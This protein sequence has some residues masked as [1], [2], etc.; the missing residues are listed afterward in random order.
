MPT[1]LAKAGNIVTLNFE[2]SFPIIGDPTVTFKSGG[3]PVN[4]NIN[5][6]NSSNDH[7]TWVAFYEVASMDN[8]GVVTFT[9]SGTDY[10]G[11][12][13]TFTIPTE[14]APSSGV[15]IDTTSPSNFSISSVSS[16]GGTDA[17]ITSGYYNA[18]NTGIDIT[19][20]IANDDSLINGTVEVLTKT[21]NANFSSLQTETDIDNI[22]S[23]L[24]ISIA[25]SKLT[26]AVGWVDGN[27][28]VFQAI[29]NDHAGNPTTSTS[30]NPSLQLIIDTTAPSLEDVN[31]VSNN[32]SGTLAKKGNT[33][34]LS[35]TSSESIQRPTVTMSIDGSDVKDNVSISGTDTS[36][37][38]TH[39]VGDNENG[40]VTYTIDY[41]D[42]AGNSGSQVTSGTGSVTVDTTAPILTPGTPITTPSKIIQPQYVFT[43]TEQGTITTNI[44]EGFSATQVVNNNDGSFT[45]T[46]T[47][48][49]LDEGT[50]ENKTITVTDAAGNPS[51]SLII[52]KF[53][54]DTTAPDAPSFTSSTLTNITAPTITGTAEA[55]STVTLT[56]PN[57]A[58][59]TTTAG[60]D[61]SW[62]VALSSTTPDSGTL[63]LNLNDNNTI[64][65][66]ATDAANNVSDVATETLVI[67]TTAPTITNV[68]LAS[69]NTTI[70]V[71]FSEAVYNSDSGSGSLEVGDF[72]FALSSSS[73]GGDATLSSTTPSSISINENKYT[74]GISLSGT[75]DGSE[76]LTVNPVLNSIYDAV[77]NVASTS[78]SN[79]TKLL[80]DKLGP[81]MTISSSTVNSGESSNDP[82]ISL[83]FTSS[84]STTNF[85]KDVITISDGDLS[86]LSGSETTYTATL[87]PSIDTTYTINVAQNTFTDSSNNYNSASNPFTWTYDSTAPAPFNVGVVTA[88]GGTVK[89]NYW[90]STNENIS[91]TV[92]I[93]SDNTLVG[94]TVQLKVKIGSYN[95]KLGNEV[96][97]SQGDL[98]AN[99]VLQQNAA[100]LENVDTLRFVD[101]VNLTFTADI[102]DVNNNGPTTGTNSVNVLT[103]YQTAPII[104]I[105]GSNPLTIYER[106]NYTDPGATA[107][108]TLDN[109]LAVVTSSQVDPDVVGEYTVTYTATDDV[110]NVSTLSRIVN[111]LELNEISL[112][113]TSHSI[114]GYKD[115][116]T[117][118][119]NHVSDLKF[120][121]KNSS[122]VYTVL[123]SVDI[124]NKLRININGNDI[125]IPNGNLVARINTGG[126][127]DYVEQHINYE[128]TTNNNKIVINIPR[129][130]HLTNPSYTQILSSNTNNG[131]WYKNGQYTYSSPD[132][133]I[134][135]SDSSGS[136]Q[137]K[138]LHTFYAVNPN[139]LD[140]DNKN[141]THFYKFESEDNLLPAIGNMPSAS[142]T[143]FFGTGI[144]ERSI[145]S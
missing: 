102:T 33:I 137:L 11:K 85:I 29:I 78:Q 18:T 12:L 26:N 72:E 121:D 75:P 43:S 90:N 89:E 97:I 110:G 69:N 82:T 1:N 3:Q 4:N 103:V 56:V 35:F 81:T 84:E 5:Y 122:G 118:P 61:G 13:R 28:M 135:Y 119:L 58:V 134:N 30:N 109:Y 53:I 99:I 46:V 21:G 60:S 111:V 50:Y 67:D 44:F 77:G 15:T 59:Y 117:I 38:A 19:I 129:N 22:N 74:L 27:T 143:F 80:N 62:S 126:Y 108:D 96:T 144:Y 57:N 54:I 73:N 20:H 128:L 93:A 86:D 104:T 42:L 51:N 64:T 124:R 127:G 125:V 66:T 47:F 120:Y 31:L 7:R 70:V 9:I 115:V 83:T 105:L 133:Y 24:T 132:G 49:E 40:N 95:Y 140:S 34:T 25:N 68:S 130:K 23:D 100:V 145:D 112:N 79:N 87:T 94:G 114:S 71:T 92:P 98:G 2:T 16:T 8:D 36:W 101:G 106:D 76:T 14:N 136:A 65:A 6:T 91:V 39:A 138:V 142:N 131:I 113:S 139:T 10:K 48:N 52:P 17:V 32:P 55:N 88:G 41:N 37:T 63:N 116:I 45:I 141:P 107:I 123:T